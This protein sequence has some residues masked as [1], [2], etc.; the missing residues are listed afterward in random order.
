MISQ[1]FVRITGLFGKTHH[2]A[3]S[4]R[5]KWLLNHKE[6]RKLSIFC[7]IASN[8]PPFYYW[9]H[10]ST[11]S[12]LNKTDKSKTHTFTFGGT[13]KRTKSFGEES[14]F[15]NQYDSQKKIYVLCVK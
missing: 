3:P 12:A 11:N 15:P 14:M 13:S 1:C 2:P 4:E 8:C 10:N 7:G 9:L 6:S 5:D